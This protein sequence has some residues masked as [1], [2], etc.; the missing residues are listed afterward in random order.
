MIFFLVLLSLTF[1]EE[2]GSVSSESD[3]VAMCNRINELID[4]A[5]ECQTFFNSL[6]VYTIDLEEFEKMESLFHST[7]TELAALRQQ[8]GE[9]NQFA[10]DDEK[11]LVYYSVRYLQRRIYKLRSQLTIL[12]QEFSESILDD[13]SNEKLAEMSQRLHSLR[14]EYESI[15]FTYITRSGDDKLGFLHKKHWALV[16]QREN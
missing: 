2:S 6:N 15:K 11:K 1:A 4:I 16:E 14:T 7:T 9:L 12:Q 10:C 13:T 3:L 5:E 8:A